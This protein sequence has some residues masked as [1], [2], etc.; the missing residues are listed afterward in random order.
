MDG[1]RACVGV[2]G[3]EEGPARRET[4]RALDALEDDG[5]GARAGGGYRMLQTLRRREGKRR[6]FATGLV[7]VFSPLST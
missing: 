7:L 4:G 1:N 5:V 3:A 2:E 6:V